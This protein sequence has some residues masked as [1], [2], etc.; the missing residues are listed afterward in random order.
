MIVVIAPGFTPDIFTS[1]AT[2]FAVPVELVTVTVAPTLEGQ[3]LREDVGYTKL[4]ISTNITIGLAFGLLIVIDSVLVAE[5]YVHVETE[6]SPNFSV[7]TGVAVETD[8]PTG[9]TIVMMSPFVYVI[10]DGLNSNVILP[11]S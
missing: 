7:H 11:V 5:V 2:P 4:L 6:N 10:P 3:L 8:V 9:N 1:F